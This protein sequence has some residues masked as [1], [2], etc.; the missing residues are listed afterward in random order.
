M[1]FRKEKRE[2]QSLPIDNIPVSEIPREENEDNEG[3]RLLY[4]CIQELPALDRA[5]V[6]LHLEERTNEEIARILGV[7]PGNVSVRLLRLKARLRR[8]LE[9]RGI[10]KETLQ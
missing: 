7:N 8:A 3:V 1:N 2:H 6:L 4:A 10:R 9:E 5:I